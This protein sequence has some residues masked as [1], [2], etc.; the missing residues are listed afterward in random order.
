ML[1]I[2]SV[3]IPNR[4]YLFIYI[5]CIYIRSLHWYSYSCKYMRMHVCMHGACTYV[6]YNYV[7]YMLVPNSL[8]LVD[9][10]LLT[11]L[12]PALLFAVVV[13]VTT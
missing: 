13:T 1:G 7:Y 11:L 6:L 2:K 4:C 12:L 8:V 3:T 9:T 5:I 10:W